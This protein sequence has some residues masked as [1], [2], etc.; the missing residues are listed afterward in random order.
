MNVIRTLPF[1][2]GPSCSGPSRFGPSRFGMK[3]VSALLL[4]TVLSACAGS[5]GVHMLTEREPTYLRMTEERAF[6]QAL[7][8]RYLELATNAYDR[9]ELARSDFYSLRAIMAVEGKLVE[10]AGADMGHQGDELG[11]TLM[12]LSQALRGGVRLSSPQLAARAQAA[13]D[14]WLV[15]AAGDGDA[16][17]AAVCRQNALAAIVNLEHI[18][19]SGRLEA[20]APVRAPHPKINTPQIAQ[21]NA[22]PSFAARVQANPQD[23]QGGFVSA[24]IPSA[25]RYVQQAESVR[26]VNPA[27]YRG[28]VQAQ[29]SYVIPAPVSL[30]EV[31]QSYI[32]I[33]PL[34]EPAPMI[35]NSGGFTDY[36]TAQGYQ[37][38]AAP[39]YYDPAP[40]DAYQP[41]YPEI[42]APSYGYSTALPAP[43]IAEPFA[44]PLVDLGGSYG[45]VVPLE[46]G[47]S[48]Q[49]M[50]SASSSGS[51]AD[52]GQRIHTQAPDT[53]M[54]SFQ[55]V[56]VYEMNPIAEPADRAE[57]FEEAPRMTVQAAPQS[58]ESLIETLMAARSAG[59][60]S[61]AV[62]FGFDSDDVTPEA[63]DVLID[64]LEQAVIEDRNT[65]VLM[66]FT[67]SAGDARYNQLLAMRRAQGVRQF[68]ESRSDRRL[69]FDIMPVGEAEAVKDGGDGI[70]EALNRKVEIRLK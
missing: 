26:S 66:G 62:Y 63:E 48:L 53:R 17:I 43:T 10:P 54:S 67:D 55:P 50:P 7:R 70:M 46:E 19:V 39:S 30:N 16:A 64:A 25:P 61:Y 32:D 31:P 37:V 65:V 6:A 34:N 45:V 23:F 12:R 2:F 33:G 20:A 13:Y 18:G 22:A 29:P 51:Y 41:S 4:S 9:G 47:D 52:S 35:A 24:P 69:R 42:S 15:E 57:M 68:L 3:V 44:V 28:S 60:T 58:D 5:G 59:D 40:I 56:P 8:Q 14:C 1:R 38:E 49:Y 21:Q 11:Q 36:G 27:T